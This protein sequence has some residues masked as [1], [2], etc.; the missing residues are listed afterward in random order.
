MKKNGVYNYFEI[1]PSA[2]QEEVKK[3]Y[4]KKSKQVHP[5]L[6]G[7]QEEFEKANKYYELL[8]SPELREIYDK[9]GKI[10]DEKRLKFNHFNAIL[11]IFEKIVFNTKPEDQVDLKKVNLI[12]EIRKV[13]EKELSTF[14]V[15][16]KMAI[17]SNENIKDMIK[18]F[19]VKNK[20]NIFENVLKDKIAINEAAEIELNAKIKS[21]KSGL[22]FLEDF[23]YQ[24]DGDFSDAFLYNTGTVTFNF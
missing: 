12:D 22:R 19:K 10:Q 24:T 7:S 14:E 20:T 17:I 1:E 15:Q 4:R 2:S 11:R 3:A 8:T 5:D 16:K 18:R 6:G 9:T 21:H 13:L 23:D